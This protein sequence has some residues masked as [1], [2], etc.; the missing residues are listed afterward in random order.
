MRPP[1]LS[2]YAPALVVHVLL[3][4]W[5]S[6]RVL[7]PGVLPSDETAWELLTT[8]IDTSLKA[9]G[10]NVE[11]WYVIVVLAIGYLT[12]FQ[13]AT[14]ILRNLPLL[15]L[16]YYSRYS[17]DFMAY[18]TEVLRLKPDYNET[19][20]ALD[21]LVDKFSK[22]IR[23]TGRNHPYQWL[24]D[25]GATWDRYYGAL[26]VAFVA[27]LV[28]ALEGGSLSRSPG[29]GLG[30]GSADCRDLHWN[31]VENAPQFLGSGERARILGSPRIPASRCG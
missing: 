27:A 9:V 26:L 11:R 21:D 24:L 10:L 15:R 3:F 30:A 17:D 22:E 12:A 31:A 16:R 13:W 18:A 5:I 28:W 6:A 20:R 23:E 8:T 14:S 7:E 19:H 1:P 2:Q 29:R 25:R 4:I